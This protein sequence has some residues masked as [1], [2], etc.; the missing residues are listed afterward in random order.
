MIKPLAILP[1]GS[2]RKKDLHVTEE[3]Y[4]QALNSRIP[5]LK[6]LQE[7]ECT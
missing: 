3:G 1:L 4:T 6:K 2:R 7:F 5:I